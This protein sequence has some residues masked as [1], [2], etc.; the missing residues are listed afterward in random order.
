MEDGKETK[1]EE[2]ERV[3]GRRSTVWGGTVDKTASEP[4]RIRVWYQSD[5]IHY[6][7]W[8]EEGEGVGKLAQGGLARGWQPQRRGTRPLRWSL[9]W[10]ILTP[11]GQPLAQ[12]LRQQ[13]AGPDSSMYTGTTA[14]TYMK[15][16]AYAGQAQ[17]VH[18]PHPRFRRRHWSK[19]F[20]RRYER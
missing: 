12:S 2:G 3:G 11:L 16:T 17:Q 15:Y 19:W 14:H 9:S 18:T 1:E 13:D 7:T 5:G 8:G 20:P 6:W 10:Q 4:E